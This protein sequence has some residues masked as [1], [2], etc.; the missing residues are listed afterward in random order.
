MLLEKALDKAPI[1]GFTL[2]GEILSHF[3]IRYALL[4]SLW[5]IVYHTSFKTFISL[6]Q[7]IDG[8]F[9]ESKLVLGRQTMDTVK[10]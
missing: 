2:I 10:A 9:N 6:V 8:T 1:I 5:R 7:H 4:N 3:I